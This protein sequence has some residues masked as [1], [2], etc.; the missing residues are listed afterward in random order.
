[1]EIID[2]EQ[3]T[4]EWLQ[5][6]LGM[7]TGTRLKGVVGTPTAQKTLRY[8]LIAEQLSQQGEQI[9]VNSAMQWGKDNEEEAIKVYK[10]QTKRKGVKK[11]GFCISDTRPFLGLSPDRLVKSGKSYV[12]AVEVKCP[13]TKTFVQY[14]LAE[15]IPDTYIWQVVH[16][17]LV[18]DTLKWLD[19]VIYDP[20]IINKSMQLK[21]FRVTRKELQPKI[22]EANEKIELFKRDWDSDYQY[23]N[24]LY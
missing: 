18:V 22:D 3:G 16:Y 14:S 1:M 21:I 23:L 7:I 15:T 8:E 2:I 19:F 20:R 4:D 10:A 24:N 6:R 9:F 12:G 11:I 17:F 5:M 13:T